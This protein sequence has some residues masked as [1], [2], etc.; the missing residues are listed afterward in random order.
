MLTARGILVPRPGIEPVPPALEVRSLNC[1]TTREV[2]FF[3]CFQQFS[4][5]G[6]PRRHHMHW[7]HSPPNSSYMAN[8]TIYATVLK[9]VTSTAPQSQTISDV[10]THRVGLSHTPQ[11][12]PSLHVRSFF[13][14][15]SLTHTPDF[16]LSCCHSF[17]AHTCCTGCSPP[18]HNG[19]PLT[20]TCT[21]YCD[22]FSHTWCHT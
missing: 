13:L 17:S 20:H 18:C 7:G 5:C 1:W 15:L 19:F 9:D 11:I 2:P 6:P 16:T 21:P 8:H 22:N 3:L 14:V 10:T 12:A 4:F